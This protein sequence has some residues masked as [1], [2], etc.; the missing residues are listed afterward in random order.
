MGDYAEPEYEL[1]EEVSLGTSGGVFGVSLSALFFGYWV[2]KMRGRKFSKSSHTIMAWALVTLA[3][4]LF[5]LALTPSSHDPN[6]YEMLDLKRDPSITPSDIRRA[7]RQVS[8][9]HHP[10]R[11]PDDPYAHEYF[12]SLKQASDILSDATLKL[13][14]D[15]WG[16]SVA[17]SCASSSS[18]CS[19]DDMFLQGMIELSVVYFFWLLGWII[20]TI[21]IKRGAVARKFVFFA[22]LATFLM[23]VYARLAPQD[24]SDFMNLYKTPHENV[25]YLRWA[26][27]LASALRVTYSYLFKELDAN[28]QRIVELEEEVKALRKKVEILKKNQKS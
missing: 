6:F 16:P 23:E 2:L 19:S 28:E 20:F 26:A 22:M 18:P 12:L 21:F 14:Y 1:M 15:R 5:F 8:R 11:K 4:F 10:D 9:V 24:V 7:F 27:F 17:R 3:A 25:V 13:G